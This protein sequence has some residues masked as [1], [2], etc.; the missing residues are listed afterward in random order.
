[1]PTINDGKAPLNKN[2][3]P[4]TVK[5]KYQGIEA[6]RENSEP[7]CKGGCW[8]F[9]KK[10]KQVKAQRKYQFNNQK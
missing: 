4:V 1:V 9:F 3:K 7:L 5:K 10:D 6:G 2:N 8:Y